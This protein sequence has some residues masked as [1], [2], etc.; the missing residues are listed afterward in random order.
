MPLLKVQVIFGSI[1]FKS[2]IL[3]NFGIPYNVDDGNLKREISNNYAY[4]S[5]MVNNNNRNN[6]HHGC[7]IDYIKGN[8]FRNEVEGGGTKSKQ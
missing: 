3:G 6:K 1:I 5:T 2:W 7:S 4:S 8:K